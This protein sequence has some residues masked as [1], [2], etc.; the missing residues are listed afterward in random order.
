M[1][2]VREGSMRFN[3]LEHPHTG[4]T[5]TLHTLQGNKVCGLLKL[6]F[7]VVQAHLT[8]NFA[9]LCRLTEQVSAGLCRLVQVCAGSVS[10]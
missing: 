9:G 1:D 7:G 5:S 8:S 3:A 10:G 6:S 2:V 4:A